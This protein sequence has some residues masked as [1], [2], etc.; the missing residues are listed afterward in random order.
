MKT[1]RS[2]QMAGV[3][4][5]ALGWGCFTLMDTVEDYSAEQDVLQIAGY[6]LVVAALVFFFKAWK[7]SV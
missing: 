7:S 3:V 6:A 4:C 1:E 5:T 2:F